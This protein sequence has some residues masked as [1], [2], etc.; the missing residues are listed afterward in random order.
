MSGWRNAGSELQCKNCGLQ[1]ERVPVIQ[2]YDCV[3]G[4][5]ESLVLVSFPVYDCYVP[6]VTDD[7]LGVGTGYHYAQK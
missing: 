6:L 4:I 5:H 7:S 3:C 1:A 2:R